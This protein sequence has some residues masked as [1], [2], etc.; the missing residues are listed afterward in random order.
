[1]DMFRLLEYIKDFFQGKPVAARSKGWSRVR[2]KYA[3]KNPRCA[4]TGSKKIQIHH[5][6]PVHLF[7]EKELDPNN[8]ISLRRDV[9][10][11]I[12]HLGSFYSYNKSIDKDVKVWRKRFITRP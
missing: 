4:I 6:Q 3:K 1:M 5:R 10:L 2:R 12:G 7:P 8:L 9:H 11:I